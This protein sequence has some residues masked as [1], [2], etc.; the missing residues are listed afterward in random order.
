MSV[1]AQCCCS[2]SKFFPFFLQIF[3]LAGISLY[4]FLFLLQHLPSTDSPA[5]QVFLV[6]TLRPTLA[7]MPFIARFL[8]LAVLASAP[9]ASA[10]GMIV[11][12]SGDLG[13]KGIGLGVSS[14]TSNNQQDVTIFGN[15]FGTTGVRIRLRGI[16]D[17][18]H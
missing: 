3:L 14:A 2:S 11:S 9:L 7:E 17:P 13:G 10:H 4:L 1:S 6:Y 8:A 12:A 5:G 15:G 18:R 16:E